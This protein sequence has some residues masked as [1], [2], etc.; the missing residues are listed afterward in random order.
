MDTARRRA[1][2]DAMVRLSDGDRSA[3]DALL[4]GLWPVILSFAERGVG[5][6]AD[7]ED[8]AQEVFFRICSRI[9]DFDPSR[10]GLSWA[11]GIASYEIMTHRKRAQRRREV[12]EES[13]LENEPDGSA[14]QEALL[15][16]RET[17]LAFEQLVG[18]LTEEDREALGLLPPGAASGPVS[19]ALRKRK[20]RA[21]ER[22]RHL[23]RSLHGDP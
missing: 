23:W 20:Q 19:A 22:L 18:T 16:E 17:R 7:A 3:F 4:D 14:S 2:H 12:H 1:I 11:F 21:L 10:D 15:M 5:R 9:T 6:G 8:I 13:S